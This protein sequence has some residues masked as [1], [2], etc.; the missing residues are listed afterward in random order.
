V[1]HEEETALGTMNQ[2]EEAPDIWQDA[3]GSS[4]QDTDAGEG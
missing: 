2:E 3:K 4:S 1:T